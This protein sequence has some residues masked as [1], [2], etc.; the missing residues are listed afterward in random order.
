M[1]K[2]DQ[3]LYQEEAAHYNLSDLIYELADHGYEFK[4]YTDYDICTLIVKKCFVLKRSGAVSY[5]LI[6]DNEKP[7]VKYI[8]LRL[9]DEV[10]EILIKRNSEKERFGE[11]CQ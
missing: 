11:P 10:N 9:L 1:S 4:I 8:I 2:Y 7:S 5:I 3:L 6:V